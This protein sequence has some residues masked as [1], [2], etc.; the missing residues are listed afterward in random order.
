[1]VTKA[2]GGQTR[3]C[4]PPKVAPPKHFRIKSGKNSEN[5]SKEFRKFSFSMISP[6]LVENGDKYG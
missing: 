2:P 5:P 3:E 6:L 1:M 4:C